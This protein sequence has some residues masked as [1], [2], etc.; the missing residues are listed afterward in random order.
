M[1]QV[2]CRVCGFPI[3]TG[4]KEGDSISCPSCGATGILTKISDVGSVEVPDPLFFGFLG[5]GFGLLFG[6]AL[7][8]LREKWG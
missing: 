2:E 5:F 8:K 6:P 4:G 7:L 3:A 1:T